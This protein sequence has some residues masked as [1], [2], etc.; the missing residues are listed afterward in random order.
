MRDIPTLLTRPTILNL[1]ENPDF[2]KKKTCRGRRIQRTPAPAIQWHHFCFTNEMPLISPVPG[3]VHV[4]RHHSILRKSSTGHSRDPRRPKGQNRRE[5]KNQQIANVNCCRQKV[6]KNHAK[7]PLVAIL[8]A[9]GAQHHLHST[10]NHFNPLET[11]RK[12]F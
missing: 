10:T 3:P 4:L 12:Q 1:T 11:Q 8:D 5:Q 7:G 2:E 9:T 6:Y